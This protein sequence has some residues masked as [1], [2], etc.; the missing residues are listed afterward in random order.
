MK[1]KEAECAEGKEICCLEC[2]KYRKC[3]DEWKCDLKTP[4][5]LCYQNGDDK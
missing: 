4:N 2:K 5:L 1:C 3:Q